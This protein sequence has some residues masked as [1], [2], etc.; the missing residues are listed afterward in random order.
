MSKRIPL[1][2]W[3]EL[4]SISANVSRPLIAAIDATFYSTRNPSP[5]YLRRIDGVLPSTPVQATAIRDVCTH[6]WLSL[7]VNN[8]MKGEAPKG[9]KLLRRLNPLPLMIVADKAYDAEYIHEHAHQNGVLTVIPS[10][11]NTKHGFYRRQMKRRFNLQ[12]YHRRSLIES[13]SL[14]INDVAAA[15]FFQK[16]PAPSGQ[17]S[18]PATSTTT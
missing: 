12:L 17:K 10:K 2:L 15:M 11:S 18:T 9:M 1:A 3:R 4:L 13:A 5:Y 16:L 8:G 6:K 14:L 7:A